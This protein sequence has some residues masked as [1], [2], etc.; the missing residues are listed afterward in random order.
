MR[1]SWIRRDACSLAGVPYSHGAVLRFEGQVTTFL[2]RDDSPCYRCIFPEAPPPR[3]APDCATAGILGV[4][5]GTIGCLQATETV[6]HLLGR[7]TPL[8]GRLVVFDA[9]GMRFDVIRVARDPACP[10]CGESPTVTSIDDVAYDGA[11]SA[12]AE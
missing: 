11:C 8:D 10:V 5:P 9:L 1:A 12:P 2:G 3:S 4:L 7:G 6:K